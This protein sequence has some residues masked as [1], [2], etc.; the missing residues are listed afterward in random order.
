MRWRS[1]G[2]SDVAPKLPAKDLAPLAEI[3]SP[4]DW[5]HIIRLVFSQI[6][7][8]AG[9]RFIAMQPLRCTPPVSECN[10]S[11]FPTSES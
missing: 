11:I 5:Q 1:V 4:K 3:V 8:R 10:C 7:D 9:Q 6:G 2:F